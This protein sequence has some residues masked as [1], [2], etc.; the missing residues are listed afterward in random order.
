V[1]TT[2]G[3]RRHR[4][5]AP[6]LIEHIKIRTLAARTGIQDPVLSHPRLLIFVKLVGAITGDAIVGNHL[7]DEVGRAAETL[8]TEP[9]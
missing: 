7:H 6:L 4:A 5:I 8:L 3:F 2:I 9:V 1:V